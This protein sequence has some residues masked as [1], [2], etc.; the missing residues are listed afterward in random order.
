MFK[1]ITK[2]FTSDKRF[3]IGLILIACL[4]SQGYSQVKSSVDGGEVILPYTQDYL[5][6]YNAA[7]DKKAEA[8]NATFR[9]RSK[10]EA[11]NNS[12]KG[13]IIGACNLITCGSFE[14][15]DLY[16]TGTFRTAVGGVNGQYWASTNGGAPYKCWNTSGTVDWSEG[17]YVSYSNSN[18]NTQYPGI[19]QPST[20]DGGGFAI[21]SY[22][23]EAISQTLTVVPNTVYTVCFEIAVIPR[24]NTVNQNNNQGGSIIE[25]D[26]N[27]DF[28]VR[29]GAVQISDPLTYNEN[30]LVQHTTSDFPSRLS[31]AT[32]G[33]GGNQN[34]GGWTKIN[35]YWENRCITFRSGNSATTVEVFYKT[36][37]PG[38]SVV[39]VDG[40]R[41]SVEGYANS[42]TVSPTSMQY[43]QPTQVALNTFVTSTTPPGAQLL[44]TTNPDITIQS[45]HLAPNPTVTTPGVWYAFYY[46]SALGCTSPSRQLT[47]T[48]TDLDSNYTKQNVTCFGG[49]NGS[50]DLTVTGGSSSYTYLW[51]TSNGSGLNP[52]AQD[53]SGLTAG[54]YNV[55]VSDGT[56]N[57]LE[58]VV[59]TQPAAVNPPVSG[60]N[61]TQCEASPIQTL[62][63]TAT[64]P[65]GQTV[66]WYNQAVGG[67][68]V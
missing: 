13:N 63:A 49:N 50:I 12:N 8:Y 28:G 57:T 2:L 27:L 65:A 44:W 45:D 17:Q 33:N 36:G 5:D 34:P 18:S 43:C 42:P 3:L 60:G 31:F 4:S 62:T 7:L 35:P 26:P 20:F 30:N 14:R 1:I 51:T 19:I 37:N 39:L 29:N 56:C 48:N 25:Y 11:F 54:T 9:S 23:N 22:Q 15:A 6:Q 61:Q 53:Q 58:T 24:Y 40:L 10:A 46:N 41:L 38:R 47:L 64:V 55:T 59:I 52:S 21:F 67:S 32:S 68:I 66:V 16:N